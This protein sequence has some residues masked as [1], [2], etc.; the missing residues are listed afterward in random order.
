MRIKID[1]TND[2]LEKIYRKLGKSF[3]D[4]VKYLK[5]VN[6]KVTINHKKTELT[7]VPTLPNL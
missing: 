7:P 4:G 1:S 3:N 2:I 5:K 6:E